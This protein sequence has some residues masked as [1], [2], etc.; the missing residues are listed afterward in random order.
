MIF[1]A[2][3]ELCLLGNIKLTKNILNIKIKKN[4]TDSSSY[5]LFERGISI[6]TLLVSQLKSLRD[7]KLMSFPN[8]K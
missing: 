3:L 8:E 7:L 4:S 2:F 5:L 6:G 1:L